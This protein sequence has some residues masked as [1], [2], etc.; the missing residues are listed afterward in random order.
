MGRWWA[1]RAEWR[2]WAFWWMLDAVMW[3]DYRWYPP[4]HTGTPAWG[5]DWA[6]QTG[7]E[8]LPPHIIRNPLQEVA[9]V[10]GGEAVRNG[11]SGMGSQ[12]RADLMWFVCEHVSISSLGTAC[13]LFIHSTRI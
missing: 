10:T 3:L 2:L 4:Q 1:V 11:Q 8:G 5:R 12:E 7:Y 9:W 6:A 13:P